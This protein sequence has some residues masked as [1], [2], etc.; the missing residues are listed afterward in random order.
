VNAQIHGTESASDNPSKDN[1]KHVHS[2]NV[3]TQETQSA[4]DQ[5]GKDNVKHVQTVNVQ[6][7]RLSQP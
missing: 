4:L 2:V 7:K 6:H 1:V 3:P 5:P